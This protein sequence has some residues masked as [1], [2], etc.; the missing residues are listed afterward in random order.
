MLNEKGGI[1]RNLA[2]VAGVL[3]I[4]IP[5]PTFITDV[6]G[7][8]LVARALRQ[9]LRSRGWA[10][11]CHCDYHHFGPCLLSGFPYLEVSGGLLPQRRIRV[12]HKANLPRPSPL[13]LYQGR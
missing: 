1:L 3:L 8:M 10:Y 7:A 2:L 4:A 6:A 11:A 9:T 13:L 5:D 12:E